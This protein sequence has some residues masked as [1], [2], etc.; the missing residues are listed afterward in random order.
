M[1]GGSSLFRRHALYQV[2]R[3]RGGSGYNYPQQRVTP[4]VGRARLPPEDE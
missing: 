3:P 1:L 4:E 2:Y